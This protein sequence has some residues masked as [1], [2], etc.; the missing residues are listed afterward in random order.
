VQLNLWFANQK[1][2]TEAIKLYDASQMPPMMAF[3]KD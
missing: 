2:H 3:G 1:I